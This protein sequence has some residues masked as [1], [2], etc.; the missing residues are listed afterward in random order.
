MNDTL[1]SLP[2][3]ALAQGEPVQ[4]SYMAFYENGETCRFWGV[5]AF[6]NH[7]NAE[8]EVIAGLEITAGETRDEQARVLLEGDGDITIDV[9]GP[10]HVAEGS[11]HTLRGALKALDQ[12]YSGP[13]R[14]FLL[15]PLVR[16]LLL[17][18]SVFSFLLMAYFVG[19]YIYARFVGVDVDPR[20][21]PRGMSYY[22]KVEAAIKSPEIGEKLNVI[23]MGQYT[24]FV[25][26]TDF[27]AQYRR[28]IGYCLTAFVLL[29][30]VGGVVRRMARYYPKA[31]F[32][33]GAQVIR[34]QKL[35]KGRE[36][37]QTVVVVGFFVNLAAGVVIV[38]MGM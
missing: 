11:A 32:S 26:V 28:R 38:L 23:L 22:Q 15:N 35:E 33:L 12:E 9:T 29:L 30:V 31:F 13:A 7:P 14:L 25:N 4:P 1:R 8:P 17:F 5:E 19:L 3:F 24:G 10:S 21:L 34:L 37:W 20:F 36:T 18:L 6:L 16:R 27:L 2:I